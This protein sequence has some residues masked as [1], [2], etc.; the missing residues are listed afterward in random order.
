MDMEAQVPEV[1]RDMAASPY[2]PRLSIKD[3]ASRFIE[4]HEQGQFEKSSMVSQ[5]QPAFAV[6]QDGV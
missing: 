3:V 1:I 2:K 4:F 5:F 6:S